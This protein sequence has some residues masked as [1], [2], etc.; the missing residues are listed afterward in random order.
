MTQEPTL[1]RLTKRLYA[2]M[3]GAPQPPSDEQGFKMWGD[4]EG[5]DHWQFCEEIIQVMSEF[6]LQY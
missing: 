4:V 1:L 6:T 2:K 5:N 3:P